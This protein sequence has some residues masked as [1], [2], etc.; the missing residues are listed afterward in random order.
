MRSRSRR[1]TGMVLLEVIIALAIF[2][3]VAFSLIMALDAATDAATDRNH[4]D[5]ATVGLENQMAKISSTRLAET[6][7]GLP[8][9]GSGITYHLQVAPESL[10]DDNRKDFNGFFRVTFQ[11]TWKANGRT[12]T[13]E[14]SQLI[15]QP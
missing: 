15:Y 4:V 12:E 10:R 6:Q 3:G 5:A 7:R 11:A 2:T 1:H 8:D 9:D 14:L 13:R